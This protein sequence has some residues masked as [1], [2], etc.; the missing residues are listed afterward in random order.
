MQVKPLAVDAKQAA[1]AFGLSRSKWYDL[2]AAGRIPK[3]F[4]IDGSRRWLYSDLCRWA[5]MGCPSLERFE[6]LKG[7]S[8]ER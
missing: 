2:Q 1:A 8:D 4:K 5:E 3:S 6:A 7:A